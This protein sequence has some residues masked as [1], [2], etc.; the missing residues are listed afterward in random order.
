MASASTPEAGQLVRSYSLEL[1]NSVPN[2]AH[3]ND[4]QH[5][6]IDNGRKLIGA[7]DKVKEWRQYYEPW[8]PDDRNTDPTTRILK[9]KGVLL[10]HAWKVFR[11]TIPKDEQETLEG[12]IPSVSGL[13][14]MVSSV[15][16]EWQTTRETN[17]SGRFMKHFTRFCQTLDSHSYMLEV[18]PIR[19]EYVSLFTGVL[20]TVINTSPML[21]KIPTLYAHIFLYPEDTMEWYRK[22]SRSRFRD[23]FRQ[24]FFDKFEATILNTQNLSLDV[25]REASVS[26]MAEIRQI[27]ITSDILLDELRHGNVDERLSADKLTRQREAVGRRR[28]E[29]YEAQRR[30]EFQTNLFSQIGKGM[31][32]GLMEAAQEMLND[33]YLKVIEQTQ[34]PR[35]FIGASEMEVNPVSYYDRDQMILNSNPLLDMFPQRS[36]E[37]PYKP[38]FEALY[39]NTIA[40]YRLNEWITE[41]RVQLL[42]ISGRKPKGLE[43]PP[44]KVLASMCVDFATRAE[45]PVIMYFC[46]LPAKEELRPGNTP[47]VQALL[48]MTYALIRQIIE[49]LP[50][51][52]SANFDF[53]RER[54][55]LLEGI[56]ASWPAAI[57]LLRDLVCTVP[58]PLF[59]I[60]D[61][62]QI[63]DDW[64][65]KDFL[66]DFVGALMLP[67]PKRERTDRLDVLLTTAGFSPGIHSCLNSEE[68]VTAERD[69]TMGSPAH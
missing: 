11:T 29:T 15:A 50:I 19:N 21:E 46:T 24:D 62:F 45:L 2:N 28:L 63:A 6:L 18:L 57:A 25:L 26:S 10:S 66:G 7:E 9:E 23:A 55:T 31:R 69:G 14:D 40:A 60:I 22:R 53:S 13:V 27:R 49:Q 52:F 41:H 68:I 3:V 58:R 42:N 43:A 54:L 39:L 37:I 4:L 61:G 35:G 20:K 32:Q 1:E 30:E 33:G 12:K 65:T 51:R 67:G 34:R 8:E 44:M 36:F 64:S 56:Q 48:S 17:K 16:K 47:E 59:C 38:P 5:A